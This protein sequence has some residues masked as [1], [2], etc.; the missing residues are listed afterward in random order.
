M[1]I[2]VESGLDSG[3]LRRHNLPRRSRLAAEAFISVQ[4]DLKAGRCEAAK[5]H[6]ACFHT[7]LYADTFHK[8]LGTKLKTDYIA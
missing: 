5:L 6:C 4:N 3:E 8:V 1:K 7:T 2:R